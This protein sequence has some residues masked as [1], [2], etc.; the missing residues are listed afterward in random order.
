[1]VNM[2]WQDDETGIC[3]VTHELFS[4][5]HS[6]T[7]IV[8]PLVDRKTTWTGEEFIAVVKR[9]EEKLGYG[10]EKGVGLPRILTLSEV[11]ELCP[12]SHIL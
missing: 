6:L 8:M 2:I 5:P 3:V 7:G 9:Y 10:L 11:E 4:R 12:V 1:M